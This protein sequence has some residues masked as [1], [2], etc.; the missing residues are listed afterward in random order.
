MAIKR[1]TNHWSWDLVGFTS[2][3]FICLGATA[4]TDYSNSRPIGTTFREVWDNAAPFY[5]FFSCVAVL[6][7]VANAVWRYRHRHDN[8]D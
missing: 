3:L 8:K 7:V 4:A 6:Y 5:I 2:V 1:L